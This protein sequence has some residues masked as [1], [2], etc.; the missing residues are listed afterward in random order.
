MSEYVVWVE[1]EVRDGL[2]DRFLPLAVA[3]ARTCVADEPG[4]RQFDVLQVDGA[5]NRVLLYEVY[6]D[7]AAFDAH[8]TMPHVA[9]F[10]GTVKPMLVKQ[11]VLRLARAAEFIKR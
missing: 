8:R 11:S 6:D 2:L 10:L 7:L 5:P 9:T 4:C 1:M 3:N